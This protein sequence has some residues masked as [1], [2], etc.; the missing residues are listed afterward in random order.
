MIF[1]NSGRNWLLRISNRIKTRSCWPETR[2]ELVWNRFGT[3]LEL[4]WNWVG[5]GLYLLAAVA[6]VQ[7]LDLEL[8]QLELDPLDLVAVRFQ[9]PALKNN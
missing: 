3:G 2:L 6:H 8:L 4:G 1:F 7:H 9:I 5:T